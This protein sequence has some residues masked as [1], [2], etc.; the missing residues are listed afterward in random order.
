MTI[1]IRP[2]QREELRETV[3]IYL[4]CLRGDYACKP[5]VYLDAKNVDEELAECEEWLYE[6]GSP[7]QLF[8]AMDGETMAGY[9]A[10]GPNIGQPFNR[11]GEVC[12]FFVRQAYRRQGVGLRLMQAGIRYLQGL[13]YQQ[14]VIFCYRAAEA[15]GLYRR[16]GGEVV[17]QEIQTPGGMPFETDVF[18]YQIPALLGTLEQ[19][20]KR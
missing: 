7:N 10:V 13:G 3:L 9:I 8:V 6:S 1:E 2:A 15:N 17:Y 4:E 5:Q 19:R 20:L 11:D 18:C 14:V 16:L 12:G